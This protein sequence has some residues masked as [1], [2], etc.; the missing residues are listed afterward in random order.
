LFSPSAAV[1]GQTPKTA[2]VFQTKRV[3]LQMSW[4]TGDL[5]PI[6]ELSNTHHKTGCILETQLRINSEQALSVTFAEY[7]LSII[8][9]VFSY[10]EKVQDPWS[11]ITNALTCLGYDLNFLNLACTLNNLYQL[12]NVGEIA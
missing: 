2:E 5:L 7:Y 8:C 1:V 3:L 11:F 4:V 12:Q 6:G 10:L 9:S